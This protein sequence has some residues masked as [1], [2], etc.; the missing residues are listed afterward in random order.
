M[1]R[2]PGKIMLLASIVLLV[3]LQGCTL[4]TASDTKSP[5]KSNTVQNVE[6]PQ[7]LP[8]AKTVDPVKAA[9]SEQCFDQGLKLYEKY[10]YQEAVTSFDKAIA[11]NPDNYKAYTSKGIALCFEGN[12]Q[13]GMELIQKTLDI[14]PDYVP[15]F[16]DMAMAYKLQNN[17]DKSIFW[18]EKTIQ[19]DPQNTW[20]YYGIATIYAD[21]GNTNDSLKYLKKAIELDQGV[22]AVAKRQAHFG[23]MRNLP[24]FQA[25]VR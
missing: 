19:G 24:E 13:V 6:N 10:Q 17:Y 25:L 20:S 8:V 3:G 1:K 18:F 22:K 7:P 9:E 14:K 4:K 21:R 15:A 11:A 2:N 12:Y 16:Y 5:I 23:Q